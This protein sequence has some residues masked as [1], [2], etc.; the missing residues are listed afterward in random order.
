MDDLDRLALAAAR[1]IVQA[2]V[3]D[4]R[5]ED[6]STTLQTARQVLA[7]FE[8]SSITFAG[9]DLKTTLAGRARRHRLCRRVRRARH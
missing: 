8:D 9:M 2:D 7:M 3:T 5:N 6:Y 4:P 1:E